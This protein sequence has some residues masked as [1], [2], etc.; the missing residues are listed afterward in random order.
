MSVHKIIC[1]DYIEVMK[2]IES[3][4]VDLIVTDPAYETLNRWKGIGTTARMGLGK[5]STKS[6]D[7]SKFFQTIPNEALSTMM[8]EFYRVLKKNT[9]CYV[10][11]DNVTLPYF[12]SMMDMGFECPE[13]CIYTDDFKLKFANMKPLIWDKVNMGMGY[14]YR[15][16]YEFILM[17]DKGRNRRLNDLSIPDVLKFKRYAGEVP[18]EKPERLFELLIKQSSKENE[19]VLDAF[20]G[21]GTTSLAAERLK[22]NSIGIE[23]SKEYC[24]LACKRLK[25]EIEQT[26]L[27]KEQSTIERICF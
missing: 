23:I 24:E 14:H 13:S 15:C 7:P 10:M 25:S 5:K 26:E 2:E 27:G 8:E 20:L 6:Y 11:C 9:H 18:T 16:Q 1:G 4:S 17:F 22:R 21:S 12:Y 3:E 19:L